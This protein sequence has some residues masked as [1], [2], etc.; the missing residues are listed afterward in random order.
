MESLAWNCLRDLPSTWTVMWSIWTSSPGRAGL[1]P[2]GGAG[3][4]REHRR[5]LLLARPSQCDAGR[6]RP[7]L[8]TLS[9]KSPWCLERVAWMTARPARGL[10][11]RSTSTRRRSRGPLPWPGSAG[12]G[13][14][15]NQRRGSAPFMG[16]A[17]V[18]VGAAGQAD[19]PRGDPPPHAVGD[20]AVDRFEDSPTP[21][22]LGVAGWVNRELLAGGGASASPPG[23][24]L[25]SLRSLRS[26]PE[27]TPGQRRVMRQGLRGQNSRKCLNL[28]IRRS[29]Y[30]F[31]IC[32]N[33][34]VR[35]PGSAESEKSN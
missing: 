24:E 33:R 19:G 5:R 31:D 26:R 23:F 22:G 4:G 13:A 18:V 2:G 9:V 12:P 16:A 35:E 8:E 15:G 10:R 30:Q 11:L 1:C 34:T 6:G 20:H 3:R 28:Y 14:P 32:T 27:Q 7:T 21:S 25:Q 17:P 29:L